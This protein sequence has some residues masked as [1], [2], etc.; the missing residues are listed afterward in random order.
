MRA[1]LPILLAS[2]LLSAA[3]HKQ[4]ARSVAAGDLK[5]EVAIDPDP[6]VAGD[7]KLRLSLR[8]AA[9]APVAGAKVALD[10]DMAAMGSMPEMKGE[11]ASREL[12]G[13]AYELTYPL[14]MLGDWTVSVRVDAPGHPPA[15]LRLKVSPPRKGFVLEQGRAPAGGRGETG[16]TL[17]ASA[18]K[19]LEIAP[20]R[21]QLIGVTFAT[22]EERPLA[23]SMRAAGHVEVDERG[24]SEVNLKY[25][26][27]ARKLFVGETGKRVAKGDPLLLLYSPDLLAAEEELLQVR[28]RAGQPGGAE[29]DQAAR[30][31][32][33]LWDLSES[34]I[35]ALEKRGKADGTVIVHAPASGVVLDKPVVDGMHAMAGTTLYRI[36]NLGRVW[37]EAEF[38]EFDAPFLAVGQAAVVTFPSLEGSRFR[39]RVSFLAPTL[40]L[41][42]RTLQAR[43]EL[44]NPD[45]L[46]KPGMF[47]D[48]R[49][50]HALG[51]RLSVADSALLLSG[52]HR[53][54]FVARGEGRL[55]PVE[56]QTGARSGDFVEVKSGLSKGD[57]VALGANFLI[58]SEALLRDALP[59]W[60]ER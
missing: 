50:E 49:A 17:K 16:P 26:A 55:L 32:L 20:E 12:G 10:Y 27:Y 24:L 38:Y 14:A 45:L 13:G 42:T 18:G 53:Y 43:I 39:G 21:L 23:V 60:S 54:A 57:R 36:G 37:V 56:V 29:L 28:R 51:Q 15:A 2:T 31:R 9:G 46:L 35:A 25:E 19:E 33:R 6:P 44:S 3:C 52:G 7:N 11:G 22:V 5:I 47:A 40:D 58:S 34:Q 4:E 41:K 8:D 59:R 1:R 30:R 48:V